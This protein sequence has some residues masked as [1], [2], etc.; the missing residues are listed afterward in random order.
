MDQQHLDEI[1]TAKSPFGEKLL[2]GGVVFSLSIFLFLNSLAIS[3]DRVNKY[4][5]DHVGVVFFITLFIVLILPLAV[6]PFPWS[7]ATEWRIGSNQISFFVPAPKGS[8]KFW[9]IENRDIEFFREGRFNKCRPMVSYPIRRWL[10]P[11]P[12]KTALLSFL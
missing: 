9:F 5:N 11:T 6:G 3:F 12:P 4:A 1:R 10:E 2:I 7:Y 8:S